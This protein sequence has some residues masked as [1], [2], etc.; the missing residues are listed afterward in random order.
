LIQRSAITVSL[1]KC[2]RQE[3][4]PIGD[5]IALAK[6][7]GHPRKIGMTERDDSERATGPSL[8]GL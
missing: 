4:S 1:T 5:G 7:R 2:G 6:K 8:S 3:N